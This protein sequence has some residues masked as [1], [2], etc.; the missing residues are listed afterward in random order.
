MTEALDVAE[1][2]KPFELECFRFNFNQFV[3]AMIDEAT[4]KQKAELYPMS[5]HDCGKDEAP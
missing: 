1:G 4:I 5:R 3:Q 2:M